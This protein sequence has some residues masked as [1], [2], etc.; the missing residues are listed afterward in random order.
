[1]KCKPSN[2]ARIRIS[3]SVSGRCVQEFQIR[4]RNIAKPRK[5]TNFR[6]Y[7]TWS[8]HMRASS[9][10]SNTPN[11]LRDGTSRSAPVRSHAQR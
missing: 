2:I 6:G 8:V 1:M 4:S 7:L 10:L 11:P 5:L 9:S 3:N